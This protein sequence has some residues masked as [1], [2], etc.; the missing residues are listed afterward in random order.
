[1]NGAVGCAVLLSAMVLG[2]SSVMASDPDTTPA[3]DSTLV[4]PAGDFLDAPVY[5]EL[6][7]ERYASDDDAELLRS[8]P[9]FPHVQHFNPVDVTALDWSSTSSTEST[10]WMQ[11]E[12]M[13][14]LLPVIPSDRASDR[15]LAKA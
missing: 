10:W 13:R 7:G 2:P 6:F 12:E 3:V 8:G 11:M 14:F 9:H 15:A 1:M 4:P 5:Y